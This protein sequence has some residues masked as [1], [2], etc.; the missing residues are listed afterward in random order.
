MSA[1]RRT[2]VAAYAVCRTDDRILLARYV[3]P[4][5]SQRHWTLPGGSVEHAEDPYDAV[6]REVA[7]ETGY[8]VEVERLLG[9][10]SRTW[11]VDDRDGLG[12]LELHG[13]GIFYSVR[14]VGGELRHE[15]G[16]ST[17]RAEWVPAHE[18]AGLERSA[19]IDVG[20]GLDRARPLT[21]RVAPVPVGGLIRP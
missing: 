11:P 2:K 7:E 14:V 1:R 3:S 6:V 13:F 10:D 21:G 8:D 9:V 12:V 15:I 20:V 18:V 19:I 5:G 16:G 17:D 4:D